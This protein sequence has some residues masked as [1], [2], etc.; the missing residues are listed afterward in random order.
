MKRLRVVSFNVK[1]G[2]N[3]KA[4]VR[5]IQR[6]ARRHKVDVFLLQEA[7]G[8]IDALA[9]MDG[10]QLVAA[11]GQGEARGN[12]MLVRDGLDVQRHRAIRCETPWT[13]PKQGQPHRGRVFPVATIDG[14]L[15]VN[16]HRT[17]PG[18]SP[19]GK[20]FA[21]E[22]DRLLELADRTDGPL[23]MAGD[24]NIGTRPGGDRARHTPWALAQAI[25]ARIVTTTTGRI[26]YA[27]CRD[28]TGTA[29]QLR[30]RYG[31]DHYPVLLELKRE[32]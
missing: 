32:N 24:Q 16:V 27:I 31:S 19:G 13:G 1:V 2:R 21:E 23:V 5:S 26:D 17:R 20:A 11:K 28:V 22:S 18:W 8:Y 30:S 7:G 25:G 4:V 29:K 15:M 14:W 3:P 10:W 9:D 6:I 12:P